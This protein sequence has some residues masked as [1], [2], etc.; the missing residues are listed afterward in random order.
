MLADTTLKVLSDLDPRGFLRTS[1][2]LFYLS[3]SMRSQ[4]V[5]HSLAINT[6]PG[7]KAG[8]KHCKD[9]VQRRRSLPGSMRAVGTGWGGQGHFTGQPA[10]PFEISGSHPAL[11]F[12]PHCLPL[13]ADFP[14]CVS[15]PSCS[16]LCPMWSWLFASLGRRCHQHEKRLMG[17]WDGAARSR[18][19]RNALVRVAP[20][21]CSAL[22]CGEQD[23][24]Q[25]LAAF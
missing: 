10:G 5:S 14:P 8:S 9:H 21:A 22:N 12:W 6:L 20:A 4:S 13:S 25:P 2:V 18:A 3:S 11:L 15:C 19:G 17:G 16:V 23:Y 24:G 1:A 7:L